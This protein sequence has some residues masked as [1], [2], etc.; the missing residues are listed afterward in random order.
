VELNGFYGNPGVLKEI[1]V[2]AHLTSLSLSHCLSDDLLEFLKDLRPLRRLVLNGLHLYNLTPDS[3]LGSLLLKSRGTL[4]ELRL[5][6]IVWNLD[7][8]LV[9]EHHDLGLVWSCVH[10]LLLDFK[11][12]DCVFDPTHSFPS[13]RT[14]ILPPLS[15]SPLKWTTLPSINSLFAHLESFEGVWGQVKFALNVGAKLRRISSTY[16][17]LSVD[18]NQPSPTFPE[19]RSLSIRIVD[20]GPFNGLARL[21]E[22]APSLTF[23]A[24]ETHLP[25]DLD[26]YITLLEDV[27]TTI[28]PL[29]LKYIKL[30]GSRYGSGVV[31][32][33][34]EAFIELASRLI[35][36]LRAATVTWRSYRVDW[37][38][39][40]AWWPDRADWNKAFSGNTHGTRFE[41]VSREEGKELEDHYDWTWD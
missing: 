41:V 31:S 22:V 7:M 28:S 8:H 30:D 32:G 12:G 35:L 34:P 5:G 1:G 15:N 19:L 13:T 17:P 18:A 39:A 25:H 36:T 23:L 21:P 38:K 4:M 29:P 11:C 24:I 10:T 6:S 16:K 26:S 20:G 37:N 9:S 3:P 33:H 27:I 2:K 14:L 40:I